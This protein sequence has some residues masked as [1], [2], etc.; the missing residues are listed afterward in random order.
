M[1]TQEI[2]TGEFKTKCLHLI[3]EVVKNREEVIITKH[4][5]PLAKLVPL[6]GQP[7]PLFGLMQSSATIHGNIITSTHETWEADTSP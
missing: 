1:T 3:D 7:S 2:A 4:G 5:Q 6:N